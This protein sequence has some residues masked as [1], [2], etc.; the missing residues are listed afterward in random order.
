MTKYQKEFQRQAD[1]IAGW[2]RQLVENSNAISKL[3]SKT[4]QAERDTAEIQKQLTTVEAHQDELSQWL[5]RYEQEVE[6]MMSRQVSQQ[7][8][9]QGPDQERERTYK[10]AEGVSE[11]LGDMGQDLTS[12]I[13]EI[14]AASSAISKTNRADDPV[15]V[16]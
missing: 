6:E 8:G 16:K 13:E 9:L 3:Y 10:T 1:K 4:W 15:R 7:D 5:D 14:N 11:R 12:M 2:D